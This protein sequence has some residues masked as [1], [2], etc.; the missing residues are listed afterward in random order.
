MNYPTHP[1]DGIIDHSMIWLEQ[2]GSWYQRPRNPAE[3]AAFKTQAESM[4][5]VKRDQLMRDS[6]IM[7]MIDRWDSYSSEQQSAWRQYRQQLRDLPGQ[8]GFPYTLTWPTSPQE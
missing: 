7:V 1:E 6:D 5:R 8:A 4:V 3:L 2:N